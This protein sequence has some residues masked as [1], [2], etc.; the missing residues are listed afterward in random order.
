[1]TMYIYLILYDNILI[2]NRS[3]KL[4]A[5]LLRRA[6]IELGTDEDTIFLIY[7]C[8]TF[9]FKTQEIYTSFF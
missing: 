2:E 8:T 3:L 4:Q 9:L 5:K 1:M 6:H 7:I